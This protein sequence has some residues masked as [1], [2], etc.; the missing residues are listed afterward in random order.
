MDILAIATKTSSTTHVA[1]SHHTKNSQ[2]VRQCTFLQNNGKY[3]M[4]YLNEISFMLFHG[5]SEN[6]RSSSLHILLNFIPIIMDSKSINTH[7]SSCI[8]KSQIKQ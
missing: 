7:L 2:A 8:F 5:S 1:K 4:F 3:T 6:S